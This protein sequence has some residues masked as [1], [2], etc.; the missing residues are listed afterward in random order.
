MSVFCGP[1]KQ[2]YNK[3]F[4]T[5]GLILH[6]DAA[7]SIS[8]PGSGSTWYDLSDSGYNFTI[9]PSAFTTGT[10]KYMNFNGS[11]GMAKR[12]VGGSLTDIPVTSDITIIGIIKVKNST[13]DY[14]TLTRSASSDHQVLI[15]VGTNNL[16]MYDND[17]I[18]FISSGYDISTLPNYDTQ[19]NFLV[20]R[21]SSSSPYY[22]FQYNTSSVVGTITNSS[23]ALNNGFAAIGGYHGFDIN[24][25]SGSQFFG[26]INAFLCYNRHLS[27]GEISQ[28][29]TYFSSRLI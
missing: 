10:V 24:V 19:F 27:A 28:M 3:I 21:L 18:G 14:R 22:Q 2:W 16:G 20:W 11:F 12:V 23:A 8:Y 13:G 15:D 26:S 6:L 5:N 7:S 1:S 25:N 29:Y 4:I 9:N 17:A